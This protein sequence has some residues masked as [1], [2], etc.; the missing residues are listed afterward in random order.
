MIEN[1]YIQ[2]AIAKADSMSIPVSIAIVDEGGHLELFYKMNNCF[3]A[4][5]DIAIKKA[6]TSAYT[7]MSTKGLNDLYR[8][9]MLF[10]VESTNNGMLYFAGGEP[11]FENGQF[12]GAIGISGGTLEEDYSIVM[13]ALS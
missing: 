9:E 2:K 10:G 12:I 8:K 3:N 4:A 1:K 13:A 5:I 6:K 11:I 7:R